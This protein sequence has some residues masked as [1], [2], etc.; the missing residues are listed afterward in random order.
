MNTSLVGG[1]AAQNCY[2][3]STFAARLLPQYERSEKS[4][5]VVDIVV[6][7]DQTEHNAALIIGHLWLG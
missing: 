2:A 7:T 1:L 6:E 3:R 5:T 4:R